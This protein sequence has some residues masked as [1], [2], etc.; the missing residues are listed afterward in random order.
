MSPGTSV[1]QSSQRERG[2]IL[3]IPADEKEMTERVQRMSSAR[4][5]TDEF[6]PFSLCLPLFFFCFFFLMACLFALSLC[7]SG[8]FLSE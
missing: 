8:K 1:K 6:S 5:T 7:A 3:S 2:E 4:W